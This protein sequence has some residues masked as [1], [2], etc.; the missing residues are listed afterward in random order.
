MTD[1]LALIPAR[2]GSKGVPGKNLRKVAG[3]S[4]VEYAIEAGK[5]ATILTTIAV[6]S[7]DGGALDQAEQHGVLALKRADGISEDV[8]PVTLAVKQALGQAE[9]VTG[10]H[11]DILV[12]LQPTAPLRRG[13]DIDAAVALYLEH[14]R[15]VCSVTRVDDNHP[16][17]M[18]RLDDD[19]RML[20][21]MP[22]LAAM[23]RQDLPPV[24][25]RNGALYVFGREDAL[26][27][28]IIKPGMT[29]Y[30]MPAKTSINID[31][32]MDLLVLDA[33]LARNTWTF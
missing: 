30:E 25:L 15:S 21:L 16:A 26:G 18:Y 4:L 19:L 6:T 12:L 33:Y 2:A 5:A 10:R 20:P 9:A 28:T 11:Y 1:I 13:A 3:L 22:E 14:G 27:E 8:S 24:Y 29:A 17:R 31:S 7:D 23:R 32:E